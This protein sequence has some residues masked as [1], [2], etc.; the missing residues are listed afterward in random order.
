MN[1]K[2]TIQII[3]VRT[4]SRTILVVAEISLVTLIPAKLKKAME[5][6]VPKQ[7]I[8]ICSVLEDW[9]NR[10]NIFQ[11]CQCFR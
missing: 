10:T 7:T 11:K 3:M 5:I 9:K 1:I 6:I 8:F 4:L 2:L